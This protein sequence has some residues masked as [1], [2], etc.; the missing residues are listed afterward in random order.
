LLLVIVV[1]LVLA[2]FVR[3]RE[4]ERWELALNKR[5]DYTKSVL[6][7]AH[8]HEL[9][10]R[11][12]LLMEYGLNNA[13]LQSE[14]G[15]GDSTM[16]E[17]SFDG[18]IRVQQ[19]PWS[20][21]AI[22]R[23]DE[24]RLVWL[25]ALASAVEDMQVFSSIDVQS[26]S[27]RHALLSGPEGWIL[28]EADT[29]PVTNRGGLNRG[30]LLVVIRCRARLRIDTPFAV[31]PHLYKLGR[32]PLQAIKSIDPAERLAGAT[33]LRPGDEPAHLEAMLSAL[34]SETDPRVLDRL[35]E[36]L[37]QFLPEPARQPVLSALRSL[38]ERNHAAATLAVR[39][40]LRSDGLYETFKSERHL[41]SG[42]SLAAIRLAC[43]RELKEGRPERQYR[44]VSVLQ[45]VAKE[46]DAEAVDAMLAYIE[47]GGAPD[48]QI[49]LA[50]RGNPRA[51]EAAYRMLA[52]SDRPR[53]WQQAAEIVHTSRRTEAERNRLRSLTGESRRRLQFVNGYSPD[54]Q[55]ELAAIGPDAREYLAR[56]VTLSTWSDA[57]DVYRRACAMLGSL[58]D[59]RAVPILIQA[60]EEHFAE[61]NLDSPHT[62]FGAAHSV[63]A[64]NKLTGSNYGGLGPGPNVIGDMVEA[65]DWTKVRKELQAWL[66]E[67]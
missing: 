27:S 53:V 9:V 64:I 12:P 67:R 50:L 29:V 34:D 17:Y 26:S 54:Y 38:I 32:D 46:N 6:R 8:Q 15:S 60:V 33:Y 52:E 13:T 40:V 59:R 55:L 61:G 10:N 1:S 35:C 23:M 41:W 22:A 62:A 25:S 49:Q 2:W 65:C 48:S 28:W 18:D 45:S 51:I 39:T 3:A 47:R 11:Q 24:L 16:G 56:L 5:A 42:K 31:M 36:R 30:G 44:T 19:I 4:R 57:P 37:E 66:D 63:Q 14:R 43:I 21:Q 20:R 7:Q 58:G